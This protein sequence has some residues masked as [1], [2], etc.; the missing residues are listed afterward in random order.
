MCV[1]VC[2]CVYIY[3]YSSDEFLFSTARSRFP[4]VFRGL[5]ASAESVRISLFHC[6]L[7]MQTSQFYQNFLSMQPSKYKTQNSA[8]ILKL[9]FESCSDIAH[10]PSPYILSFP[11]VQPCLQPTFTIIIKQ[12][13]GSVKRLNFWSKLPPPS[14]NKCCVSHYS[15]FII[16]IISSSSSSSS[17]TTTS[18][19]S[20]HLPSPISQCSTLPPASLYHKDKRAEPG[21]R[22]SSRVFVNPSVINIVSH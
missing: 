21:K 11:N 14:R 9:S 16:I 12:S 1:C 5:T 10:F 7:H 3:I 4:V 19:T 15:R 13:P 6:M 20:H 2:V 17:S 8:R 22:H 18:F